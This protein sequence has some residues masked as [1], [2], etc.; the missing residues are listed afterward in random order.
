MPALPDVAEYIRS[1]ALALDLPV[2]TSMVQRLARYIEAVWT[3]VDASGV[4]SPRGLE[5]F[6]AGHVGPSLAACR[7]VPA[8]TRT[9]LDVGTGLGFPGVPLAVWTGLDS[10]LV[11]DDAQRVSKVQ[12]ALD[13]VGL[14]HVQ[15]RHTRAEA[16]RG[17][18]DVVTA[19]HIGSEAV[20]VCAPRVAPG[21]RLVVITHNEQTHAGPS[22]WAQEIQAIHLR[23][24]R[25]IWLHVFTRPD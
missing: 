8:K 1:C 24:M 14:G 13:T 9:M 5:D 3:G 19:R 21:G 4:K 6:I 7:A 11:D 20:A 10:V 2:E 12:H 17:Q 25:P 16:M 22:H 15:A 18:F 23:G